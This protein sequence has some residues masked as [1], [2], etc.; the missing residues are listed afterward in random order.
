MCGRM[1]LRQSSP[2]VYLA[3][4]ILVCVAGCG[5]NSSLTKQARGQVTFQG[6]APPAEGKITFAPIESAPNYPRR[7][8]IGEFDKTGTFTLTTF[9]KD[10]GIIPG[11]YHVNI[12]CWREPPTLKTALSANYV[13]ADFK[14]EV[15]IDANA[16][17]PVELRIDV[18]K[19]QWGA[20]S[21]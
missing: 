19:I 8:A 20:M 2:G 10:D 18:P 3:M 13:P 15:T 16:D 11:K 21:R 17:E 7:P 6:A 9:A 14:F 5:K 1:Y 12:K 4:F